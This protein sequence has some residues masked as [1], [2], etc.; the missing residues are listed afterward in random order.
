MKLKI[1]PDKLITFF[2]KIKGEKGTSELRAV[3]NP[4]AEYCVIPKHEAI[5]LGYK[6]DFDE[7][8]EPGEGTR[9]ITIGGI[10]EAGE[11]ELDEVQ[12]ADLVSKNVKTIVSDL[13][14]LGGVQFVMGLS[15]LAN[16][17][18]TIDYGKGYLTI[19][20]V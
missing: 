4:S 2:V 3:L 11:V 8:T 12:V 10:I 6:I 1:E 15:F 16:Y 7:F 5:L 20:Q 13:P 18:T 14:I 17:K 19:E 9:A